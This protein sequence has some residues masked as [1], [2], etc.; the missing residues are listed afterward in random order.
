VTITAPA[1]GALVNEL[2]TV[3]WIFNGTGADCTTAD[4]RTFTIQASSNGWS[5]WNDV[6]TATSS[7]SVYATFNSDDPT[8]TPDASTYEFRLFANDNAVATTTWNDVEIDNTHPTISGVVGT[9]L[10][11]AGD[12]IQITFDET[13]ATTTL[14]TS[15]GITSIVG[16]L[17]GAFDL[18]NASGV[19][20]VGDTVYTITLDEN[21]DNDFIQNTETIT[22]NLAAT[23]TDVVGNTYSVTPVA[24]AAVSKETT[25][26][27]VTVSGA[28][29][30]NGGDTVTLTFSENMATST[31]TTAL[32]QANTNI[33][34][35]ISDNAG[36]TNEYDLD[37]SNATIV[38]TGLNIATITLNELI[39]GAYI[40]NGKYVG[41]TLVGVTD[42]VGN[43][44]NEITEIYSAAITGDVTAPTIIDDWALNMNSG[45]ITL[46]FDEPMGTSTSPNTTKITIQESNDVSVS[47]ESYTLTGGT[48]TW[49]SYTSMTINL[50][51]TDLNALKLNT[52][53]ATSA[54]N[55]YLK[56]IA[57]NSIT[58]LAGNEIDLTNVTDGASIN[59][60][61]FTADTTSPSLVNWTLNMNTGS[62]VMNFDETVSTSTLA[63]G[64]IT[65]QDA[66]TSTTSYVLT[67][68]ATASTNGTQVNIAL[69]LTDLNA[70]KND[71]NLATSTDSSYLIL[72]A[73]AIDDMKVI[74]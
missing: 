66:A 55:S 33:T 70:I 43:L 74:T 11:N 36:N 25:A 31:I 29:V 22:V 73:S 50:S 65:I 61:T 52:S 19:W 16:S 40:P 67:D 47:G 24:S 57:G 37:L 38:W 46:N 20:S 34:I 42:L 48:S 2:V 32:L 71:L 30:N 51:I 12:T 54:A 8:D 28:S 59:A 56:I 39:D 60:T 35:D 27:T 58:D 5:T 18:S 13:I 53:I 7:T 44:V 6:T 64:A 10:H 45:T 63:V 62:L 15:T 68:S 14:T 72:T 26:P 41:V 23:V 17:S 21:T 9:S 4:P 69:S 3:S 49:S 1:S